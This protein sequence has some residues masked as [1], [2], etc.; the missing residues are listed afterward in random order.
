MICI[1][2]KALSFLYDLFKDV[3]QNSAENCLENNKK[4]N[5]KKLNETVINNSVL[6]MSHCV[7]SCDKLAKKL[8][9]TNIIMDLLYL[10]RDGFNP[11]MQ[12]NCGV[13][14]SRL[15]KKDEK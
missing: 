14:I 7:E 5:L 13:L 3:S 1:S 6:C 10:T 15:A 12:K 11:E 2:N 4:L 9:S 8:L